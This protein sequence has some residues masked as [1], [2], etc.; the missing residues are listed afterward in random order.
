ME[1]L[2]NMLPKVVFLSYIVKMIV[3]SPSSSDV[4]V[5]LALS[6]VA[7]IQSYVDKQK[8][9]QDVQANC[10]KQIEEIKVVVNKQIETIAIQAVE[11][12]KL[13]ND[14]SGIKLKN[15]FKSIEGFGGKKLG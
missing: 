8:T 5:I 4:G 10:N 15:D 13:R 12:G 11:F 1:T 7:A 9:I 3:Y 6:A 2:I 14:M